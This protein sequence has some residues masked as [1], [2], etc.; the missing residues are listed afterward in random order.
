MKTK[1]YTI[2]LIENNDG[3]SILNRRND[4]FNGYELLGIMEKIQLD[5]LQ[6]L[7][8]NVKVDVVKREVVLDDEESE[9]HGI[10]K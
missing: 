4:G 8:G 2:E 9:G 5:I 7:A 1:K 6:Q 3:T 10:K